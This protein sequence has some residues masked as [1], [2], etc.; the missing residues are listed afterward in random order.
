M[1]SKLYAYRLS[2]G[3]RKTGNSWDRARNSQAFPGWLT[4]EALRGIVGLVTDSVA[5]MGQEG[6]QTVEAGK[7]E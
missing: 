2:S 7:T 5:D 4:E 6:E 1:N 3:P